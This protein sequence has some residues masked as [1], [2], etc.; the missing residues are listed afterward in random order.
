MFCG[1][2]CIIAFVFLIA[3]IYVMFSTENIAKQEFYNTLSGDQ[4]NIYKKLIKE[5]KNI[6]YG[7]FILGIVLSILFIVMLKSNIFNNISNSL[8]NKKSKSS[9]TSVVCIVG[10][11]T[12]VTNYLFYILYPKS[13]F[14]I[15]HLENKEQ[16]KEWLDIYKYMQFRYHLGF[17]LGILALIFASMAIC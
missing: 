12:F 17:V 16:I 10:A 14:M 9:K 4:K 1:N 13:D 8:F 5:R 11:I 6:Y 7:G 3:N 2:I 15:L